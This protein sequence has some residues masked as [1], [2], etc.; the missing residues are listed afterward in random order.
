MGGN[1]TERKR[2]GVG[3]KERWILKHPVVH[4]DSCPSRVTPRCLCFVVSRLVTA[5]THHERE[6]E[7]NLSTN[8]NRNAAT[9]VHKR[10]ESKVFIL[11]RHDQLLYRY[12]WSQ[13]E[14]YCKQISKIQSC[15]KIKL[16]TSYI[17][18]LETQYSI[19][20]I[21]ICIFLIIWINIFIH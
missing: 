16:W 2:R 12:L 10:L 1:S 20:I 18:L 21:I 3:I 17:W 15:S 4:P 5:E 8:L 14:K 19:S 13:K 11:I 7:G 9:D 6:T